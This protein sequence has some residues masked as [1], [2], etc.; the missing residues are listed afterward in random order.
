M[1]GPRV[2]NSIALI[3]SMLN[4]SVNLFDDSLNEFELSAGF[5][6]VRLRLPVVANALQKYTNELEPVKDPIPA[7]VC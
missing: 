3:T 4:A 5:N 2:L 7:A 6:A 1:S